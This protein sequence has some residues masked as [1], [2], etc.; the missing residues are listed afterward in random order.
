MKSP[1]GARVRTQYSFYRATGDLFQILDA[2]ESNVQHIEPKERF[3]PIT[4]FASSYGWVQWNKYSKE[5]GLVPV[6]GIELGITPDPYAKKPIVDDWL[7]FPIDDL[8]PLCEIASQ[9]V[10]Q[11]QSKPLLSYSQVAIAEGVVKIMGHR[12]QL[13]QLPRGINNLYAAMSPAV[14]LGYRRRIDECGIPWASA[15]ENR[16][17]SP[18]DRD[19]YKV[20]SGWQSF[21]QSYPQHLLTADEWDG[22]VSAVFP[23]EDVRTTAQENTHSILRI[24][25][26]CKLPQGTLPNPP[27]KK[28][29]ADLCLE[30]DTWMQ[31]SER[32]GMMPEK[33]AGRVSRQYLKR[34][35]R[36]LKVIRDIGFED[37]FLIVADMV[38]WARE[39]M[40]VGPARGSAAGS[41]VCYL[42]GITRVDPITNG[43]LFERFLDPTRTDMPDIDVD[44]PTG[45]GRDQVVDYL[46]SVYGKNRVARMGTVA[47]YQSDAAINASCGA[48]QFPK[49]K[50]QEWLQG[51]DLASVSDDTAYN[52]CPPAW[53]A[54]KL[55][56]RPSHMGKHAAGVIVEANPLTAI[57]PVSEGETMM[58]DKKDAESLGLLKIDALVIKQV[59]ILEET[60]KLLDKPFDFLEKLPLDNKL[61]FAEI[62][63]GRYAGVFQF[64]KAATQNYA[65]R[66]TVENFDDIVALRA[67]ANPGPIDSGSAD[68]WVR[69]RMGE[70]RISIPHPLFED[71]L[72]STW[73]LMIYQEQVMQIGRIGGL[74]WGEVGRLRKAMSASQGS[75]AIADLGE[76]W[77]RGCI[78]K[79][80][81]SR[82]VDNFWPQLLKYGGWTFNRSH[83]I[84]Y[85]LLSY[86]SAYMKANY[87][88]AYA[89][90][91]LNAEKD[92]DK[93]CAMLREL[94]ESGYS[95]REVD[96]QKSEYKWIVVDNTLVGPLTAIKGIGAA[97]AEEI[98][99]ARE[100][101][102]PLRSAVQKKLD[103]PKTPYADLF[104]IKSVIN[105]VCPDL[106]KRNIFTKPTD[107]ASLSDKHTD[108]VILG[109][110]DSLKRDRGMIKVWLK[111]DTDK[112][113]CIFPRNTN[114]GDL[115]QGDGIWCLKGGIK[116]KNDFRMFIA[117]GA[118][119]LGNDAIT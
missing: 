26:S 67:I 81:P 14:T 80:I 103:S 91:M 16:Y 79:G 9:A 92:E 111:D 57:M 93:Q 90:C 55:L 83:S 59:G 43:L 61:A 69:R 104:P 45:D 11:R 22:A 8:S 114:A 13:D 56:G 5:R 84:S 118:R 10:A 62:N 58:L 105:R 18:E 33:D 24:A 29:L 106:K 41:L 63:E 49:W 40:L 31:L 1:T 102:L 15:G 100:R 54:K 87:K 116:M 82:V 30:G 7:F 74:D 71:V 78:E 66:I 86:W 17:M 70:E 117:K 28:S 27:R 99:G 2:I 32:I 53:L 115:S 96:P 68:M 72:K 3:A 23:E 42:T 46:R 88:E 25:S 107:I 113:F 77:K 76:K 50:V 89:C 98:L 64:N 34:L 101:G 47:K 97:T 75:S 37:Y 110:M 19:V 38:S 44:F 51:R 112:V 4:D 119:F 39:R 94:I 36:E 108:V 109:M 12:T 52:Q 21:T 6:F 60:L 73:G 20:I 85:A 65:K 48:L 95:Y 35:D